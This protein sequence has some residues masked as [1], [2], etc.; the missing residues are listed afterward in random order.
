MFKIE[1]VNVDLANLGKLMEDENVY[2]IMQTKY[3]SGISPLYR[4]RHVKECEIGKI[5]NNEVKIVRFVEE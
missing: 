5:L 3:G 1:E 2:A 4:L